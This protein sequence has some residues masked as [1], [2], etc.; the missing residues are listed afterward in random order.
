MVQ[1]VIQKLA[2]LS[3]S[4]SGTGQSSSVLIKGRANLTMGGSATVKVEKSYDSGTT[5]FDVSADSLGTLASYVMSAA[6]VS[7]VIDE[8]EDGIL[9]RLNCTAYTSATTYRISQ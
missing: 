3:G 4:F 9:Y 8:P 2:L 1:P 5:W 7:V 6:E